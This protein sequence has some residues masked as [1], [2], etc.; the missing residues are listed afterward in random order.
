[1]SKRNT[2]EQLMKNILHGIEKQINTMKWGMTRKT[3]DLKK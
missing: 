3:K 1:M 2:K